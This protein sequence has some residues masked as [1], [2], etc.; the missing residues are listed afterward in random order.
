MRS[1]VYKFTQKTR[2]TTFLTITRDLV[3][4]R[5]V[6][7]KKEDNDEDDSKQEKLKSSLFVNES[8]L[9]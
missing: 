6:Y 4:F 3:L 5:F 9:L 8:H 7:S 2:H 1:G